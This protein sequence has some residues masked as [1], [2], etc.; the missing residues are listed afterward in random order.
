VPWLEHLANWLLSGFLSARPLKIIGLSGV[1]PDCPVIPRSNNQLR[2]RSTA[3]Q[4][5]HQRPEDS[6][7]CQIAPDCPVQQEDKRLQRS[8]ALNPNSQLTWHSPDSEQWSV[9]CTTGLFGVPIDSNS[10]N[11]GWG[12]KY[13][14][15][16][17]FK[18]SNHTNLF[19]QYK[20]K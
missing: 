2:Q 14:Q 7:R 18:P 3:Q 11:S 8:T 20:S 5:N 6:L 9:R 13:P 1:P 4:S 19:I 10:W 15:P 17:P 16:L 12:Y